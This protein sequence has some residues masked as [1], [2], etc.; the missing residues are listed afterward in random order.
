MER[1]LIEDR[2]TCGLTNVCALFERFVSLNLLICCSFFLVPGFR[3]F[4]VSSP[5]LME[6]NRESPEWLKGLEKEDMDLLW[7]F[8]KMNSIQIYE[9]IKSLYNL[10]VE[11]NVEEEREMIRGR[12]LDVLSSKD[13]L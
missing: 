8:G 6:S 4:V 12:F 13:D 7:S 1:I 11:L 5:H 10:A 9:K 2:L 3:D